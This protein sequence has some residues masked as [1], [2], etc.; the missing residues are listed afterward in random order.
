MSERPTDDAVIAAQADDVTRGLSVDIDGGTQHAVQSLSQ[1][2]PTSV[3]DLWEACTEPERLARWFAP[4]SGDLRPGGRYAIEGNASGT[5]EACEA[6]R[7]FAITW[8]FGGG[9]SQVSV[10]VDP[11]GD[12]ARLTLEHAAT[13][14]AGSEFW[15]R[16]GPGATG[17]GWDLSLLGLALHLKAGTGRPEDEEAFAQTPAVQRFIRASSAAWGEASAAAGTPEPEARA[18]AERTTAFYLGE[19]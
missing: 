1:T 15:T 17:V 11:D 10:R 9:T 13:A 2:Y 5:I 3:D 7:T 14:E 19:D 16:Y 6:P 18:A 4:V 12:G 8:E